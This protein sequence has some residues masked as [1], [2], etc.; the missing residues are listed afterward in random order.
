MRMVAQGRHHAPARMN[1]KVTS[2]H[3]GL[4][5]MRDVLVKYLSVWLPMGPSRKCYIHELVEDLS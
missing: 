1:S 5:T 4:A 2:Y 3:H